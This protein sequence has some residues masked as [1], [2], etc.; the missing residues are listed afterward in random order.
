MRK[1]EEVYGYIIL[2]QKGL[3]ITASIHSMEVSLG[4]AETKKFNTVFGQV[5]KI[6]T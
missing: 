4:G 1:K 2:T 3:L 6:C 5:L